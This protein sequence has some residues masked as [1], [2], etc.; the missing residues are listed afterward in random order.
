MN[1]ARFSYRIFSFFWLFFKSL[2]CLFEFRANL[3][4]I[5]S[6]INCV[7][8]DFFFLV[9]NYFF[10]NRFGNQSTFVHWTFQ[11]TIR[12]YVCALIFNNVIVCLLSWF[13][14]NQKLQNRFRLLST[15]KWTKKRKKKK[16]PSS[17]RWLIK[18]DLFKV[19]YFHWSAPSE[20]PSTKCSKCSKWTWIR[21]SN[22]CVGRESQWI[23]R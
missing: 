8:C 12:D 10:K 13:H 17:I 4:W 3:E 7:A 1:N 21:I 20:N 5:Q 19:M 14:W 6:N 22:K 9:I 2:N 23:V 18:S 11:M 15:G 16:I